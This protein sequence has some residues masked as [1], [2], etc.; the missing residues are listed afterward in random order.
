[1][2]NIKKI[3]SALDKILDS[4]EFSESQKYQQL[5]QYLVLASLEGRAPKEFTI[6]QD[7]FGIDP[8][9]PG[10][11]D[12]KVRVYIYNLRKKL[13]SYYLHEGTDDDIQ[14][15]IPK[16]H[17]RVKFHDKSS[18][19]T[20][21]KWSALV[22]A[23]IIFI[24][25]LIT[26]NYF[27]IDNYF[28]SPSSKA[29]I[30]ASDPV[31]GDFLNSDLPVLIVFGDY[32]LYKDTTI[33]QQT[34]YVRDYQIN[35]DQDFQQFLSSNGEQREGFSETSHTLLGKFAPWSIA[36]IYHVFANSGIEPELK[37]SSDLQWED[38]TKYNIIFIGTFKTLGLFNE[39]IGDHHFR[40][41]I[42]PNTLFYDHPDGDTS[43]SYT[44]ITQTPE[45]VYET[46]YAVI[47][48][49][50]GSASNSILIF[51]ST[52]D[53]GCL[54]TVEFLTTPETLF[55]FAENHLVSEKDVTAYFE[56]VFEVQGYERNVLKTSLLH[57]NRI[58]SR[59]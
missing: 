40:Y 2:K 57:F 47:A 31:W 34:R 8:C 28:S 58:Y 15:A 29:E 10:T 17:Y 27:I 35:S 50:P 42:S 24:I 16:G 21:S 51:A 18:Q 13:D 26:G 44:T 7:V 22:Y 19:R 48:K 55:E 43:Y 9:K 1:M 45:S 36:E 54:A 37:L 30:S 52:R 4:N 56:A 5:L 38:I 23:N 6:A 39:L 11:E 49:Q 33:P 41:Q 59:K 25:L 12:T 32:Y 53:I 46:D 14:F 3:K 20:P